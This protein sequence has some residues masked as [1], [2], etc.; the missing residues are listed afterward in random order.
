MRAKFS[1]H[2]TSAGI[3]CDSSSSG[4]ITYNIITE[5]KGDGIVSAGSDPSI[6]S[7]T[8][9]GNK[10]IGIYCYSNSLSII[11]NNVIEKNYYSGIY[12]YS[13]FPV[14]TNNTIIENK[15]G[16]NCS[17]N[18]SPSLTNNIIANNT[19][20]GISE[21]SINSDPLPNYN[22]FF[23]N[24]SGDYYDY[25]TQKIETVEWLNSA[26]GY[27]GN[28][29][30]NPLFVDSG[31]NNYSLTPNSPCIDKGLNTV[32]GIFSTDK[33]GN[34][35]IFDGDKDGTSTVDIGAYEFQGLSPALLKEVIFV[36][37]NPCRISQSN[38]ITFKKLTPQATIRIFNI[39]REEIAKIEHNNGTDEERWIMPNS[40]AS[41]VYLYLITNNQK[42]TPVKGK[43]GI[44]K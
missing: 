37:P 2:D 30:S 9:R 32:I 34:S 36:F 19:K 1:Q 10:G 5:N 44:I 21:G 11:I 6:I 15:D 42:D 8:I 35:R 17:W 4:T 16:I 14:I 13:S 26:G 41:G 31:R 23:N 22:C 29:V 3:E 18:S 12:C 39:A 24:D 7:N 43:I 33:N 28:I 27:T 25:D 40:L 38:I 20:Y